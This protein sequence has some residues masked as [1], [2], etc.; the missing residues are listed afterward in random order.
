MLTWRRQEPSD[1]QKTWTKINEKYQHNPDYRLASCNLQSR[2]T[3]KRGDNNIDFQ[4]ATD[5]P[6]VQP[7]SLS[8][9]LP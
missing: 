9:E 5:G 7:D 6:V 4:L 1:W 2:K 8:H 3:S